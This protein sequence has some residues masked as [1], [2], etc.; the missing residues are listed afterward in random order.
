MEV[1]P[2]TTGKSKNE[3]VGFAAV[4]SA[5]RAWVKHQHDEGE[6]WRRILKSSGPEMLQAMEEHQALIDAQRTDSQRILRDFDKTK[7]SRF[8][9]SEEVMS[10]FLTHHKQKIL[11]E[12]EEPD[13]IWTMQAELWAETCTICRVRD[14]VWAKHDWRECGEHQED[15]EAVEEAYDGI[16]EHLGSWTGKAQ[17]GFGGRCANCGS[18]RIW[19]WVNPDARCCRFE[20]VVL[21]SVAA[22]LGTSQEVVAKCEERKGRGRGGPLGEQR[23]NEARYGF[24]E[25]G[26]VWRTFGWLGVWDITEVKVD[27]LKQAYHARCSSLS[28]SRRAQREREFNAA[29]TRKD[30]EDA[31][32]VRRGDHGMTL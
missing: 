29:T 13:D 27:E 11:D 22:M 8:N 32:A 30:R 10:D 26:R 2:E 4:A 16:V 6:G 20:G 7:M 1:E 23:S 5:Y 24:T 25:A 17:A 12:W 18:G 9:E 21:E 28:Y 19:C 15:V 14:G 3:G 31:R